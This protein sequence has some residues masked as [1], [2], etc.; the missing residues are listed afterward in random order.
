ME[1]P[2]KERKALL[3]AVARFV[4]SFELVFDGDWELTHGRIADPECVIKGT[5]IHPNVEDE[6][7]NW[8]NRGSLLR[9]YRHLKALLKDLGI[10][11]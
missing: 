4:D 11:G 1:I 9:S 3:D 6:S 2:G 8:G 5:F 10:N 7:N